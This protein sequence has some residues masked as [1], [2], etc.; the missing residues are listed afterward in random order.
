MMFAVRMT[1]PIGMGVDGVDG[2]T[3]T[4]IPADTC[5]VGAGLPTT[6]W[7]RRAACCAP[8]SDARAKAKAKAAPNDR[9]SLEPLADTNE[10]VRRLLR[11]GDRL[12]DEQP[13]QSHVEADADVGLERRKAR[14]LV[15]RILQVALP[16][17]NQPAA[18]GVGE[19]DPL[20]TMPPAAVPPRV[21]EVPITEHRQPQAPAVLGV[22]QDHPLALSGHA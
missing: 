1:G 19:H 7:S 12:G 20:G 15:L 4:S 16:I 11:I 22:E 18:A 14:Q 17:T 5:T 13:D 3:D 8:A 2:G 9:T 21:G 10:E 6:G